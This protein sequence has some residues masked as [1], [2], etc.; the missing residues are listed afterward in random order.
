MHI[1]QAASRS[2]VS[3]FPVS[4]FIA[5]TPPHPGRLEDWVRG[6]ASDWESGDLFVIDAGFSLDGNGDSLFGGIRLLKILRLLGY[7]QHCILYSFLPLTDLLRLSPFNGILLS[8]GTTYVRLPDPIDETLCQRVVKMQC[9]S[10]LLPFFRAEALELM[11]T[12]R[13]SL[14]N[15]WGMVRFYE[16][17]RE[18]G[19]LP[20]GAQE[21]LR[22]VL[23][24][25]S[26]YEGMVMNYVRFRGSVPDL[27]LDKQMS[28]GI[29]KSSQKLQKKNLKVVFVDD[30]A[31]QGWSYLLQIFLYGKP[32]PDRFVVPALRP[33]GN[34]LD[35]L[36][37]EIVSHDPDL[38]I[39]DI[40]LEEGDE[41][42]RIEDLSGMRLLGRLNGRDGC[43]CPI[44]AFTA[45]DKR[46]LGEKALESGADAVWTKE[47]IDE[48]DSLSREEFRPFSVKR[49]FNLGR[50]LRIL[51]DD[52]YN[53]LYESLRRIREL[54]KATRS[55]W[56]QTEKW[57]PEDR[58]QR[59][60]IDKALI[61]DRLRQVFLTHKRLLSSTLSEVKSL[62]YEILSIKLCGLIELFHP[63]GYD[64]DGHDIPLARVIMEDWP[65]RSRQYIFAMHLVYERNDLFH[66]TDLKASHVIKRQRYES[67]LDTFWAYLTADTSEEGKITALKGRLTR[68]EA[69]N[70]E[71]I[72]HLETDMGRSLIPKIFRQRCADLLGP[73]EYA[74]GVEAV[75]SQPFPFFQLTDVFIPG[76]GEET[77]RSWTAAFRVGR[78]SA[79]GVELRL[80]EILVRKG[81]FFLAEDS[82]PL[83]PGDSVYFHIHALDDGQKRV[84]HLRHVQL[85]KPGMLDYSFWKGT[86]TKVWTYD[87][88]LRIYLADLKPPF[89]AIFFVSHDF[90]PV[91]E[92]AEERI[93][94]HMD[95]NQDW[96]FEDIRLIPDENS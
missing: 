40:R 21:E 61:I 82:V 83:V 47:G 74:D 34:D 56:W 57:Y 27:V 91:L 69:P 10:D 9:E 38:V 43:T 49:F 48:S 4:G 45:S 73:S 46:H 29:Q 76:D 63:L 77:D 55:Y 94:F 22:E 80:S 84:M 16:I 13:H 11:D 8:R 92:N 2:A 37:R 60:P 19:L 6:H 54:E 88:R 35:A 85:R 42:S 53:L 64:A 50:H 17:L 51:T 14:A 28:W 81:S 58:K 1:I 32:D 78:V 79:K 95:W 31:S 70:G 41:A 62:T 36:S 87:G 25:D 20:D 52:D 5:D 71:D 23:E 68:S 12:G 67:L 90:L 7:R 30:Q 26:S 39:L 66:L 75:I 72:F 89:N 86:V 96:N 24:R 93:G 59:K 3:P 15:W 44:L 18:S 33:E 65:R